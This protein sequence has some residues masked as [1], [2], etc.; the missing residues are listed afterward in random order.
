MEFVRIIHP[1]HYDPKRRRFASSCFTN[2]SDGKGISLVDTE[3]A[4]EHSGSICP[5]LK[6]FYPTVVGDP[7]IYWYMPSDLPSGTKIKETKS[8]TGDPCHRELH[9]LSDNQSRRFYKKSYR[10][11][12]VRVCQNGM[13][14]LCSKEL[15]IKI[16]E[17]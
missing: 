10:V 1:I 17:E 11:D 2:S 12:D 15:L 6:H 16:F 8:T 14:D 13:A 5:H 4:R 9:C 7:V 3:C